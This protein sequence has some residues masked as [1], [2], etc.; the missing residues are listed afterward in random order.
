MKKHVNY[1]VKCI[2]SNKNK[3]GFGY[4]HKKGQFVSADGKGVDMNRAYIYSDD[5]ECSLNECYNGWE[6]YYKYI[7]VT[8]VAIR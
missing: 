7:A 5:D 8:I 2:K 6:N 3:F 4:S 1:V